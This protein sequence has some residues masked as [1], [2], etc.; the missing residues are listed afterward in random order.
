MLFTHLRDVHDEHNGQRVGD[1]LER[2]AAASAGQRERR[3]LDHQV[4]DL[5]G[6]E[7]LAARARPGA[8]HLA[9]ALRLLVLLALLLQQHTAHSASRFNNALHRYSTVQYSLV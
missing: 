2:A 8:A 4:R 9:L 6:D 1:E 7:G 3:R 5:V